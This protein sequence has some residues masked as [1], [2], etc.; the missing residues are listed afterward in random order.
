MSVRICRVMGLLLAALTL[1][2]LPSARAVT[3]LT[4]PKT[5][6]AE[7]QA[8]AERAIRA[9]RV[10]SYGMVPIYGR[11]IEDGTYAVKVESTSAFFK[12]IEAEL[13]VS[14]DEMTANITIGSRSYLYV[15]ILSRDDL[16]LLCELL[17][18][19]LELDALILELPSQFFHVL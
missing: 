13:T 2:L 19:P 11:D 8:K 16:L 7:K 9:R 15:Y 18:L 4:P 12:I 14:G 1:L 10:G 6:W 17:D 3:V 5:D